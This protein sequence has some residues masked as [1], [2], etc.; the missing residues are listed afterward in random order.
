MKPQASK[1]SVGAALA[2]TDGGVSAAREVVGKTYDERSQAQLGAL[3]GALGFDRDRE[4]ILELQR[5]LFSPW[6][7]Y[8]IPAQ[9]AY[10]S[11]IGDDHSPYEY[12]LAFAGNS[13]ELRILFEAQAETP[14]AAANQEAARA[15]NGSLRSRFGVDLS[16][17][18]RIEDLFL[19]ASP[20]PPLSLWHA[21]CLNPGVPAAFKIYLN[22]AAQGRERAPAVVSEALARLGMSR[23][24][25]PLLQRV[26]WRGAGMDELK[27]LSLDLSSERHARVKLYFVHHN[28]T[29]AELER[30]FAGAGSHRSGDVESFCRSMVGH[31]GPFSRKSVTSCFSFVEGKDAPSAVTMH[32]PI[33]HYASSD[34]EI[35]GRVANYLATHGMASESYTRALAAVAARPLE[36][37]AGLQSYVS[38]RREKAGLR[39]TVYLSPE[40]FDD[41]SFRSGVRMTA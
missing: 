35:A 1:Q 22:P 26:A 36:A 27:Y 16:R 14:T 39:L 32:L 15:V 30:S 2:D 4:A 13:V 20:L 34:D 11:F 6:G 10:P 5:F 40:L 7:A 25:Q 3:C 21:V 29:A 23:V 41:A 8:T 28:V 17:L 18:D 38:Y 12:S 33:A 19:T 9:P 37:G 24:C 31:V